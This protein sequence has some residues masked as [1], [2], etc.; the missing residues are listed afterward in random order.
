MTFNIHAGQR[1]LY[2]HNGQWE[3]G[4]LTNQLRPELTAEGLFLFVIPEEYIGKPES[5]HFHDA[6]INDIFFDAQPVEDWMR[7]YKNL[8]TKD[9]YLDIIESDDFDRATEHAY[10]S[11]GEYYYYAVNKYTAN[12]LNKQPFDYIV[13]SEV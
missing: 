13:R 4:E 11:D 2:K 12:W 7:I 9:E 1:V 10:V 8:V 6:E 3:V 5:P